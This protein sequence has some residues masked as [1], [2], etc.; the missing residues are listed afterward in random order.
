MQ[1]KY[2]Y[3]WF[4]KEIASIKTPKF[5]LVDGPADEKLR[6]AIMHS[7][8]RL[9]SSYKEF[10]L[11]FGNARLY[12]DAK[13]H[14]YCV[15][16]FA[17]PREAT[18]N[19][20]TKIYHIGFHDGAS[21]YVKPKAASEIGSIFED[22]DGHEEPVAESFEVWLRE[23]CAHARE[24]YGK[25]EWDEIV[26]GPKPFT[27]QERSMIETRKQIHWR[28]LGIDAEGKRIFEIKNTGNQTLTWLTVGVRSKDKRLN[29]AVYLNVQHIGPGQTALVH[30]YCYRGL[31]PPE[32]IET[33]ILPD[34]QPEDRGFYREFDNK[35]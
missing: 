34:P 9:D 25:D 35:I 10:V 31:R 29:G 26:R 28:V 14:S 17:G 11:K 1:I 27:P 24:A 13:N 18:L 19:D 2:M 16:V 12:R 8:L 7:D 15:G 32:E 30:A 5:H 21:V 3:T 20:G 33:F 23:S 6:Y 4:Q 22:Q